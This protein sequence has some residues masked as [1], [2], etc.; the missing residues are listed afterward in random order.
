MNS[1]ITFLNA[2]FSTLSLVATFTSTME[3]TPLLA[4]AAGNQV[5]MLNTAT[6]EVVGRTELTSAVSRLHVSGAGDRI[7]VARN[8]KRVS[9]I[10]VKTMTEEGMR[11]R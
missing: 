7:A 4:A 11:A 10:D 6:L 1:T 3:D 2:L 9:I 5:C 8:D